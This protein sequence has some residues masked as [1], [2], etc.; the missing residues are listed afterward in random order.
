[1]FW[2]RKQS[3]G[4]VSITPYVSMY[5]A[6]LTDE[7]DIVRKRIAEKLSVYQD[8]MCEYQR[9]QNPLFY[10][11]QQISADWDIDTNN[12]S[13]LAHGSGLFSWSG[14]LDEFLISDNLL[15][16]NQKERG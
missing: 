13:I 14:T 15:T 6:D 3:R 8:K 7:E 16:N 5:S 4:T 11:I 2:R 10:R 12:I 1:M 9:N